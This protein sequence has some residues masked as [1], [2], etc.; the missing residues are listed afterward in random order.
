VETLL[1]NGGKCSVCDGLGRIYTPAI[2]QVFKPTAIE[3]IVKAACPDEE[4]EAL[5]A[6]GIS[7]VVVVESQLRLI[8]PEVVQEVDDA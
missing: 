7:P 1:D 6:R 3:K 4:V 5:E 8:E 2:F